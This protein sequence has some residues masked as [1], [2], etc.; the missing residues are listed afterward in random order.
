M[1]PFQIEYIRP[2]TIEGAV[3][4]Y[5]ELASAG[6]TVRYLLGGTELV[7]M[8][9]D[10]KLAFDALIDL[11]RIPRV[12]ESDPDSG[13]FGAGQRLSDLQ[14]VAPDRGVG[15]LVRRAAG[16]IADHTTRNS[17]TLGGNVCGMLPYREAILPFLA[18]SGS[19][20]IS[21]PDGSR[22]F[23]LA[24][25]DKRLRLEPGEFVV[26]LAIDP[27]WYE[28]KIAYRRRNRDARVDY[29]IVTMCLARQAERIR[30][31]VTG[32]FGA[33]AQSAAAN[34]IL[35]DVRSSA[36]K[37][38]DQAIAAFGRS[39]HDDMR[40]SAEYREAHLRIALLEGL[41]LL[42]GTP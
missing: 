28:S 29:P 41:A 32:A 10:G 21:G 24:G 1:I 26:A 14:H 12:A 30:L 6:K 20:E 31:A 22:E 8:A 19:V 11:K 3:S 40:A 34:E 38:V 17:I 5:Q 36:E 16:G 13:R 2:D 7:T 15:S 4:A 33:P 39:F 35:G 23:D 27:I 42:E 25:F 37:R 18:V 9:R